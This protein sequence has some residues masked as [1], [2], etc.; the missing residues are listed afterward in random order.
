MRRIMRKS[1]G[2]PVVIPEYSLVSTTATITI[3]IIIA[4]QALG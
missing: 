3:E 1:I 2:R 4:I